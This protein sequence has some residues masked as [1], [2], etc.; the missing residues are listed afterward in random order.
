[1][2]RISEHISYKEATRSATAR[3]YNINNQPNEHQLGNMIL[4][5]E[6]IFEPLRAALGDKTIYIASFFRSYDLNELIGGAVRS[7]HMANNG[8]AIDLDGDIFGSPNNAEIFFTLLAGD[9]DFD[10]LIWEY[11]D[12]ENPEWVHVSYN[13]GK[14][15]HQVLKAKKIGSSTKYVKYERNV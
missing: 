2:Q 15:R 12:E 8:A 1:M 11:G 5:A 3:R 9:F 13:H 4:L 6:N 7:Q 14:N 10:Q